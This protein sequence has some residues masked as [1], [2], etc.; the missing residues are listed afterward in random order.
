MCIGSALWRRH[1]AFRNMLRADDELWGPCA[2]L[3]TDLK[4]RD[5]HDKAAHT[6]A[7]APFILQVLAASG[8][9]G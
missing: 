9:A 6:E 4:P 1:L 3:K 8:E 7:K 2:A 5:L